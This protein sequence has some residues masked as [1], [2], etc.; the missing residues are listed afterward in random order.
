MFFQLQFQQDSV[1]TLKS[2]E[3]DGFTRMEWPPTDDR[4]FCTKNNQEISYA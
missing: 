1:R 3:K 4:E 2:Y